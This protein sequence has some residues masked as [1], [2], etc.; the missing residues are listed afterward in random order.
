MASLNVL[1]FDHESHQNQFDKWLDNLQL[2]LLSD[3]RDS[4]SLFDHTCGASLAPPATADSATRSQWLIHDAAACLAVRNHLPLVERAHFGKH[5]T[6]KALYDVVVT[7][8]SSPATAAPGR[9]LLPYLFPERS[10]FATVKD[11]VT[12]LRTSNA[13]YRAALPAE[14]LDRNPPLMDHFL[15]HDPTDLTVDLLEQHLLAAEVVAAMGVVAGVGALVA[16]VLV[17]VGVAVVAAVRVV[18][19]GVELFRGEVLAGA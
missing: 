19:V 18:A 16:A 10:A 1:T 14:F 12:H 6:A 4:V 8:Y 11:L 15:A 7:H 5:K 13:R 17:E 2:Y 9:L 3:Y